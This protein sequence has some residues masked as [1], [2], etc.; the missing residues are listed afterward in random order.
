MN[1]VRRGLL[2]LGLIAAVVIGVSVPAFV[3][4]TTDL[5]C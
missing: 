4:L 2:L 5:G 1:T 3:S